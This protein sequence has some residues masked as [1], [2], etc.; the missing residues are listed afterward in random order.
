MSKIKTGDNVLFFY[1]DSKKVS[2]KKIK[3]FFNYVLKFPSYVEGLNHIRSDF[4]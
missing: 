4:I 1:N 2:N 3:K